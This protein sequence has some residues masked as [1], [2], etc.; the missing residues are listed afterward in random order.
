MDVDVARHGAVT[1]P[2]GHHLNYDR[3]FGVGARAPQGDGDTGSVSQHDPQW[4][5]GFDG[6]GKLGSYHGRY[7]LNRLVER[8]YNKA[9]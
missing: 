7:S 4:I 1:A 6:K 8:S 2:I 3:H 9:I 5:D